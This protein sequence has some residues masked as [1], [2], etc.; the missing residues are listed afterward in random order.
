MAL[1]GCNFVRMTRHGLQA[2]RRHWK[3]TRHRFEIRRHALKL[4]FWDDRHLHPVGTLLDHT[5][6]SIKSL[7]GLG[8]YELRID[9]EVG[10]IENIRAIFFD[11]PKSWVPQPEHA[12]PLRV[13][14]VLEVFPKKNNHWTENEIKRFKASRLMIKERFYQE[15]AV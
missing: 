12:K 7:P 2:A 5:Y 11:P 13:V 14:W 6:E 3:S 15:G 4:R 10:G 9:D 1:T 8:V